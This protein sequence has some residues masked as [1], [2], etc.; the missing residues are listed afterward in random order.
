MM[1]TE[2][3]LLLFLVA[4]IA[5]CA[6]VITFSLLLTATSLWRTSHRLDLLLLHSDE[7]VQEAHRIFGS[8]RALMGVLERGGAAV[9]K[10]FGQHRKSSHVTN[11]R[12]V[13]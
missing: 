10:L 11:K 2:S 3:P 7:T 4:L 5:L 8:I 12:R 6:V 13:A 9:Q 1:M